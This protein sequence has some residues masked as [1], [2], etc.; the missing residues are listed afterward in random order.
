MS[1][2]SP[3]VV[4]YIK[5]AVEKKQFENKE[6]EGGGR[7]LPPW[8]GSH[9][10]LPNSLKLIYEWVDVS[11]KW[12]N[13]QRTSPRGHHERTRSKGISPNYAGKGG[14]AEPQVGVISAGRS[15]ENNQCKSSRRSES[16]GGCV[17]ERG[18]T[19][20]GNWEKHLACSY[21]RDEE[22]DAYILKKKREKGNRGG[23]PR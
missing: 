10:G 17:G 5:E 8:S 23:K 11:E 22:D 18:E 2:K 6:S 7:R 19:S 4:Y 3:A 9:Q 21:E 1:A 13:T 16:N 20:E 12:K 14:R 15:C